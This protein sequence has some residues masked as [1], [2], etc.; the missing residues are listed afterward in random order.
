MCICEWL[1][2]SG[3]IS[4]I[5]FNPQHLTLLK[6]IIVRCLSAHKCCMV[7][8]RRSIK[9]L[10]YFWSSGMRWLPTNGWWRTHHRYA[11]TSAVCSPAKAMHPP[12]QKGLLKYEGALEDPAKVAFHNL[13]SAF[14]QLHWTLFIT[15]NVTTTDD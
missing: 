10:T 4:P 7:W 14:S 15:F 3:D 13:K 5:C 2:G 9:C 8:G 1:L 12:M 11:L 6:V